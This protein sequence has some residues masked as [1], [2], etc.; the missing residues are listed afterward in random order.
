MIEYFQTWFPWLPSLSR[1]ELLMLAYLG[2]MSLVATGL[3]IYGFVRGIRDHIR[4]RRLARMLA[5]HE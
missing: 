5:S 2:V 3:M 1:E 4:K